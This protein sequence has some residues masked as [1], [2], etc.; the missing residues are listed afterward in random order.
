VVARCIGPSGGC[1]PITPPPLCPTSIVWGCAGNGRCVDG[2]CVCADGWTGDYC[3][4]TVACAALAVAS[5]V[6][7]CSPAADCIITNTTQS[8][9]SVRQSARCACRSGYTGPGHVCN[10]NPTFIDQGGQRDPNDDIVTGFSITAVVLGG[11]GESSRD[12]GSR[13]GVGRVAWRHRTCATVSQPAQE[14]SC[15]WALW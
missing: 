6:G 15:W 3:S 7:P 14:P 10:P 1:L 4:Q 11:I 12:G 2:R 13:L 8:D 9:G 5:G